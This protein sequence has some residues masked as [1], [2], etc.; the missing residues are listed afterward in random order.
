[1]NQISSRNVWIIKYIFPI[2]WFGFLGFFII[3]LIFT[4]NTDGGP[5]TFAIIVP[6]AMGVFG[7][8]LMKRTV[9]DL[10]DAVLDAGD[11]L[12]VR[13]GNKEER[14]PLANIINISYS[15]IS[16][17]ARVT[18]MLRERGRFGEEVSFSPPQRFVP[19]SRSP[20][21]IELIR[22]VDQA[23]RAQK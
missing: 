5:A 6:I 13:F 2:F 20:E 23:R 3:V 18:L 19:F 12:V 7:Y 1:M 17:P 21:I 14:I 9:W 11:S 4:R 10:A 15:Y 8:F 16:G 22:R